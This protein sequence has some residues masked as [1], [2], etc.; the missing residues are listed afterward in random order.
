MILYAYR[1]TFRVTIKHKLFQLVYGLYPLMLI[2]YLLFV[3]NSYLDQEFS[4]THFLTSHMAKLEHLDETCQEAT[5]RT[6]V[7]QR[8]MTL[9]PQENHKIKTFLAWDIIFQFPKGKKKH[10]EKFKTRWFGPYK[11][12]YCLPNNIVL[13]VNIDKFEPNPILVNIEKFKPYRYLGRF[14]KDHQRGRKAQGGFTKMFSIWF[15]QK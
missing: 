8:K 10:I 4:P 14:L 5:K 11:I 9:W 7:R 3:S 6:S 2:K 15:H 12:Q 13:F 1:T